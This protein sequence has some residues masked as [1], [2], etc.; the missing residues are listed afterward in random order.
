MTFLKL[1]EFYNDDDKQQEIL[2]LIKEIS[3]LKFKKATRQEFKSHQFKTTK[4]KLSQL[5][6]LENFK[7]LTKE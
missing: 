7:Q 3:E 4:K 6:T 1:K 5:L 2:T